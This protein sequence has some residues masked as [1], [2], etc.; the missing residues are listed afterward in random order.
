MSWSIQPVGLECL[1]TH[2]GKAMTW[3]K[4]MF[5]SHHL[6]SPKT[7]QAD[8]FA[9]LNPKSFPFLQFLCVACQPVPYPSTWVK[10]VWT[11][12]VSARIWAQPKHSQS[13]TI[14]DQRHRREGLTFVMLG[15]CS[16][17]SFGF[18][19]GARGTWITSWDC[20]GNEIICAIYGVNGLDKD[21][22]DFF[23]GLASYKSL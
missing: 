4:V 14:I 7:N 23:N 19:L 2:K 21:P 5:T 1:R 8:F 17:S 10:F 12:Y 15:V 6:P 16:F 13:T 20:K 9:P 11:Q 3:S 22:S 18:T